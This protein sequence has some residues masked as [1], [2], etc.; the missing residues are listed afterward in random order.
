M[1]RWCKLFN[2]DVIVNRWRSGELLNKAVEIVAKS[3]IEEWRQ[4]LFDLRCFMV[5]PR[6]GM[7][8]WPIW[9]PRD[10]AQHYSCKVGGGRA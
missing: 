2:G 3:V 8:L 5:V 1:D 9:H 6:S 4:R 7:L 10:L